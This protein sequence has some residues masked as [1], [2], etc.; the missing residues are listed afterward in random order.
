MAFYDIWMPKL[1]GTLKSF[2]RTEGLFFGQERAIAP[3]NPSSGYYKFYPK[4]DGSWYLLDSSGTETELTSGGG[5]GEIPLGAIIAHYAGSSL[6][7][8]P[9]IATVQAAGFALCDGTT[10]ATQGIS[11]ATIT[12]ATP[13]LNGGA[14]FIR[15][16]DTAGTEQSHQLES[17]THS[18]GNERGTLNTFFTDHSG[19]YDATGSTGSPG[20]C[21]T[22][23]ETRPDYVTVVWFM[24]VK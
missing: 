17:H 11:G 22:G 15:A 1:V 23:S 19:R 16:S 12:E 3:S 7:G 9:S 8:M 20:G 6:T 24:R 14:E 18:Y 2:F 5:D 10:A 4:T 13:D 21:S